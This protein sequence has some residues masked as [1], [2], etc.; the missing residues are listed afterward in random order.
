MI[1]I[2]E[3]IQ[4][5]TDSS[6]NHLAYSNSFLNLNTAPEYVIGEVILASLYRNIGWTNSE[7]K[8]KFSEASIFKYGGITEG[9]LKKIEKDSR[10]ISD[11]KIFENKI[12]SEI[13][14][15]FLQSPRMKN[16]V[17]SQN[18]V[19][20]PIVADT[21]LYSSAARMKGNPWNPGGLLEES[22]LCG[23]KNYTEASQIWL[24]LFNALNSDPKD[25]S[26][27]IWSRILS[28]EFSSWRD[29][30]VIWGDT[31]NK[32]TK[33]AYA[34]YSFENSFRQIPAAQFVKD[35]SSVIKLKQQLT[36]KQ[37]ISILESLLRLGCA[38][39]LLWVC[40]VNT[41]IWGHLL[42]VLKGNNASRN[43]LEER[44]FG[45]NLIELKYGDNINNSIRKHAREYLIA[46]VGINYLLHKLGEFAPESINSLDDI[47]SLS[48][49]IIAKREMIPAPEQLN[50]ELLGMLENDP[51]LLNCS[52]GIGNN[53]Y[54]FVRYSLGQKK[55]AEETQK[56]FDQGYWL[57]KKGDYSSAPWILEMGP[58][59]IL[60]MVYCETEPYNFSR[61]INSLCDHMSSYGISINPK[62]I[63]NS[64][65][66]YSLRSLGLVTDSPDAE[67][68][69]VI[70][71]PF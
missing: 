18:L 20:Y 53:I 63:A 5:P 2:E 52:K 3:F 39:H 21:S 7:T 41:I 51:K 38:S 31:P 15:V 49:L 36:R 54:E 60:L 11:S 50:K 67:G 66:A 16:Q 46:R 25:E 47:I 68:G 45:K 48:E 34:F 57:R 43:I 13:L 56:S 12:F 32:I 8:T 10:T 33:P 58:V 24:E 37:W 6:K 71:K 14:R 9:L 1:P 64:K 59:A 70:N 35:I 26:E 19:L 17:K 4:K 62:D 44:I 22:I 23:C 40:R 69:M 42:D 29:A 28:K 61:T 55:T 27:D 30:S 65:L